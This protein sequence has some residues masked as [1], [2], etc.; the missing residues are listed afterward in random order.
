M[1]ALPVVALHPWVPA[2]VTRGLA[3]SAVTAVFGA[4]AVYQFHHIV[5]G[6]GV[7]AP[8][9]AI[10]T[11][12]V[13]LNPLIILYGST[14]MSDLMWTGCMLG[15]FAGVFDYLQTGSLGRL[16]AAGFWAAMGFGMRYEAIPFGFMLI[17]AIAFSLWHRR[18]TSQWVGS[19]II[20]AAPIVFGAGVWIYFNWLIMKNPLYFLNSSYGN[21]AQTSTGSY[22]TPAVAAADHN[23]VGTLLYVVRFG[24]LYW[25]IYPAMIFA[26]W[27]CFGRQRDPRAIILVFG[28][29]G[30]E[31]LEFVLL[32]KGILGEWDRYFMEFIPNGVLLIAFAIAKTRERWVHWSSLLK[33]T[34]ATVVSVILLSGSVGTVV[35]I[36]QTALGAPDGAAIDAAYHHQ[37]LQGSSNSA[38]YGI[39][40]VVG[41]MTNH[42][43]LTVL[44]DTFIDWP[45]ITHS[46]HLNQFIITSDYNFGAVLHNPRGQVDAFL[47]PRPHGIASLDAINRA[48]P[49]LWAGRVP[50]TELITQ[51]PG[52]IEYRLYRSLPSAP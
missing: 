51:F 45:I 46:P 14:G 31:L 50:W 4:I 34:V 11:L 39:Q 41:Y 19:A 27:F 44:A 20:F 48:W 16:I 17:L 3:G 37:P 43:H 6:F 12:I 42:P 2:V 9:R 23:L 7:G 26:L 10:I 5:K 18:T 29:I 22:M 35:A 15:S 28:T 8:W 32:Y 47:V 49:G 30:A 24:E 25:P 21:L 13:A 52:P 40:G 38:S 1:L 33:Y 36:Q